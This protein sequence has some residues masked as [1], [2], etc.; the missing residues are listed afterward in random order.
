MP[1][2]SPSYG[3]RLP[4]LADVADGPAA[5]LNMATDIEGTINDKALLT[6]TP[7][8]NSSGAIQPSN[9]ASREGKYSVRN[10]WCDVSIKLTFGGSTSGGSGNLDLGLPLIPS[11]AIAEALFHAK[12]YTPG[13][14]WWNGYAFANSGST[15]VYPFFPQSLNTPLCNPWRSSDASGAIGTGIPTLGGQYGIASGGDIVV[16]GRY[17][18]G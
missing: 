18:V 14:G 6:Y 2:T 15:K 16:Y 17:Y 12:L 11:T 5:F 7:S 3:W 9:P 10:G 8:W 4:T 1:T 13:V